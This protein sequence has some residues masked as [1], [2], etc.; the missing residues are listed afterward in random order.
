M[1]VLNSYKYSNNFITL[2]G[3]KRQDDPRN[4]DRKNATIL[5]KNERIFYRKRKKMSEL[6]RIFYKKPANINIKINAA[7]EKA[8]YFLHVIYP[9]RG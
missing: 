2:S 9:V 4:F 8:P 5:Q 7:V 1:G 3:G 6:F